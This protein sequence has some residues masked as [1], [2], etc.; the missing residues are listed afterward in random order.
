MLFTRHTKT[1]QV[2][3]L[4]IPEESDCFAV[5]DLFNLDRA[6]TRR[7]NLSSSDVSRLLRNHMILAATVDGQ[8]RGAILCRRSRASGRMLVKWVGV[9]PE[10]RRQGIATILLDSVSRGLSGRRYAV[11][12]CVPEEALAAQ[13][14]LKSRGLKGR[15]RSRGVGLGVTYTFG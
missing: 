14:L 8:Y 2:V 1:G 7:A 6:T 5:A 15:Q 13:H 12:A 9:H 4:A 3:T 11:R 10:Y